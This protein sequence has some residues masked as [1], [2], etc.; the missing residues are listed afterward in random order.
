MHRCDECRKAGPKREPAFLSHACL[1]RYWMTVMTVPLLSP[2]GSWFADGWYVKPDSLTPVTVNV[3]DAAD[4]GTRG[5]VRVQRPSEP[6][7]HDDVPDAPP[8][9][10]PV[11][12][13]PETTACEEL[14]T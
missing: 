1:G 6:V 13:A 9:Q 2:S 14:C 11:T 8:D 7:V 12:T 10:A 4:R 3:I 5:E